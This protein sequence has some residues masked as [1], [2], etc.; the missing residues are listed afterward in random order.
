MDPDPPKDEPLPPEED[1]ELPPDEPLKLDDV[2][3][4][5]STGVTCRV[6]CVALQ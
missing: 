6:T 1:P 3:G 2:D 4:G 5:G